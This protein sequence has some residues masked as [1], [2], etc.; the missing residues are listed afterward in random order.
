MRDKHIS[1][2][3]EV[4]AMVF[5][6]LSLYPLMRYGTLADVQVPQH[7]SKDGCVDIWTTRKY[8]IYLGLFSI[9]LYSILSVA[10]SH[11]NLVNI[12][13]GNE[14]SVQDRASVAKSIA[15][16]IKVWLMAFCAFMSM[17]SYRIALGKEQ[18]LNDTV[19][20]IIGACALVH[21]S[22]ILLFHP[23]GTSDIY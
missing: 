4:L 14:M 17:S 22:L 15:R 23:G 5:L 8:F 6:I 3:L 1:L 9:A 20:C 21:I 7:Y 10:Q 11:P 12:P 13:H 19:S 18:C 16:S 2:L